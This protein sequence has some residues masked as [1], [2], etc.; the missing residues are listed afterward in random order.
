MHAEK[1]FRKSHRLNASRGFTLVE[2]LLTVVILGLLASTMA[3]VYASGQAANT[4]ETRG[5]LLDSLVRSRMEVLIGTPFAGLS[6]GSEAVT[7]D[8]ENFSISWSVV[9]TDL[10]G[11]SM[12]EQTARTV[13]V[14]VTGVQGHSLTMI[15]VDNEGLV[16]KI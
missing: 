6:G 3:Y 16:G 10:D 8:G 4:T 11:D 14:W 1:R 9:P 15:L 12:P 13:T 5:M 2:A 7:V